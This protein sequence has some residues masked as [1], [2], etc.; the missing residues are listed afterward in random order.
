MA[1]ERVQLL[2]E[3][4]TEAELLLWHQ[5]RDKRVG[6]VRFRR[7]YRLGPF[8]T[9]FVCLSARLVIEVGGPSHELIV[10][11]DT[12]R[13]RWLEDQGFRVLRFTN[14]QVMHELAGVVQT[15]GAILR[16]DVE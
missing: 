12:R 4:Q 1:D 9:D 3:N 5:L 10:D 13:T 6:G 8:I 14:D 15:I 11:A 7:Q 16:G 2:R